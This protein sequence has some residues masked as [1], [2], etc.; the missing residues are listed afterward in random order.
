[1]GS[2]MCI[3]DSLLTIT[4]LYGYKV[5]ETLAVSSL[6]EYKTAIL[7]GGFND[8]GYLDIGV[9][10]T[11]TPVKDLVVVFHPLNYNFVFSDGDSEYESSLGCKVVADYTRKIGKI[12]FKTNF[13]G[14]LSYE[15][16]DYS[17]WQWTNSFSY[18]IWKA[19]GVGFDFGLRGN[20]QEAYNFALDLDDPFT[21]TLAEFEENKLQTFWTAGATFNF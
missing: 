11:W 20:K 7:E 1:M 4:S 15:D 14:F 19:L 6:I 9:G 17:N 2:E 13:T 12:N 3:R 5:T 18:Q 8:P 10:G 16:T 21:G